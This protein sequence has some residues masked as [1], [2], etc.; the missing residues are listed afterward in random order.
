MAGH[1]ANLAAWEASPAG[2]QFIKDAK[3]NEENSSAKA[4]P[5]KVEADPQPHREVTSDTK[6]SK[7]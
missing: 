1:E 5:E 3:A 6:G 2:Q 4:E 7:G